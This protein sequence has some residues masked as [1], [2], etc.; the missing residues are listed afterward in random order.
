MLRKLLHKELTRKDKIYMCICMYVLHWSGNYLQ[1]KVEKIKN[2][3]RMLYFGVELRRLC[4]KT[5]RVM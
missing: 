5:V 3:N 4:F 1:L 2:L